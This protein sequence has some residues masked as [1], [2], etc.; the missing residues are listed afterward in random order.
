[1]KEVNVSE[2][3]KGLHEN[4]MVLIDIRESYERDIAKI[5]QAEHIPM[6]D[7]LDRASEIPRDKKVVIHCRSGQRSAAVIDAL[8]KEHSFEN[9]YNLQGGIL[10][11]SDEIDSSLTKY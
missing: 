8:E 9:L 6:G 1:M 4:E 2:L 10:A 3:E 11:W 5:D 7:I